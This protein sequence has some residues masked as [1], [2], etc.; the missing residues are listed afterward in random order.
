MNLTLEDRA[1][2]ISTFLDLP[3]E[4]CIARLRRGFGYQHQ[5]VA[6]DW[7]RANPQTDEEILD[8]YRTTESYIWE[9]SAYHADPGFNY[10]GMCKGI[11]DGLLAKRAY[12][13]LCLGDGIGDLT[14]HLN[15]DC[16]APVYHDL[17]ASNTAKFAV[18]RFRKYEKRMII[19]D[20]TMGWEPDF[21][22]LQYDAVVSLDF[23][24]H[25]PE[26]GV[27]K[28]ARAIYAAVKPGGWFV[29]QNGFAMG[30]GAQGSIP[31]HLA[32]NDRFEQDWDPLL[33]SIG[34]VQAASNWYFRP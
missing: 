10:S 26:G 19:T 34:F 7:R 21:C 16:F 15:E 28:W 6:Q 9:L 33:A 24:E 13:V 17:A 31:C 30:S 22:H 27:E 3:Y 14:L 23:L 8:W 12:R 18:A 2:E 11:A 29:A 32:C 1:S 20:L 25:L 4:D 5:Q